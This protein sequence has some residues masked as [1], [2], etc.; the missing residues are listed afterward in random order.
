MTEKKK[1]PG[2]SS[3]QVTKLYERI[4]NKKVPFKY[5][6][7]GRVRPSIPVNV[8]LAQ[9][10]ALVRT[11]DVELRQ[12]DLPLENP[13]TFEEI[14][15][16]IGKLVA[17]KNAAY[18]DSFAQSCRILEVLFPSGVRPDQ[19]RDMLGLVRVIDKMFRIATHKHALGESP[20]TDI[21][22]Y[23]ILGVKNDAQVP[24]IPD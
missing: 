10:E 22:G 7:N 3:Y 23:G 2:R 20:W 19:Y 12:Q 4:F 9:I 1:G 8:M 17:E 15:T 16:R 13:E 21:T 24:R 5:R 18:G 6:G 11:E 14:G